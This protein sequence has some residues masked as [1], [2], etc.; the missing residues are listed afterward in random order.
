MTE[1]EYKDLLKWCR[2]KRN[3]GT[4]EYQRR[5]AIKVQAVAIRQQITGIRADIKNGMF[6]LERMKCK[7]KIA[8]SIE[9]INDLKDRKRDLMNKL[10]DLNF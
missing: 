4:E 9:V 6:W 2:D 3:Q 8:R 5:H 10:S 1:Q 7:D